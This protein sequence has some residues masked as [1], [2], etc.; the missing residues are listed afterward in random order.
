MRKQLFFLISAVV[1]ASCGDDVPG[2]I[3]LREEMREFVIGISEY[4]R[5]L[6]DSFIVIP[7]NGIELVSTN[8]ESDGPV[9][10]EYLAAID[11]H[12]QEDLF[13]GYNKDDKAT[14][15]SDN[16]YLRSYLDKSLAGGNSIL[17]TDYCSTHSNMDDSYT[18]NHAQG[19]VS[20][21]ANSRELDRIP[22][23]PDPIYG[24]NDAE[25][26]NLEDVR[27]FLYMINPGRFN[28]KQDFIQ[29]V[30]STNYDLL[31]MDLF[32]N[33]D[34]PFS[35]AEIEQLKSK[36][37]GETRLVVAYMSI[38]EAEDY[39]YYWQDDWERNPPSWMDGENPSW[40][41]NF[42][43]WYW[44]E[45]WQAIIY[46]SDDSYLGKIL[47]AGFDGVYLDIIDAFEH[48]E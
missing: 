44:E 27:N 33:D 39:R 22:G 36:A 14:P 13:Y 23:Y 7:Q 31:I 10:T 42:K 19:Y 3:D 32:F 5:A 15:E 18:R 4:A 6:D 1:M 25:I 45:E 34:S 11:G 43:V 48:Y 40:E 30:T 12:G 38:G 24:E 17:V 41:G 37:N 35:A 9:H 16:A 47:N 26:L 29:A 8:G 20:F 46:G 28:T 21:A 2:D